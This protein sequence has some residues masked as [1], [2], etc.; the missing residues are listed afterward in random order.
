[1]AGQ[2][3]PTK[4][5]KNTDTRAERPVRGFHFICPIKEEKGVIPNRDG[6]FWTG[7]WAVAEAHAQLGKKID[8]YV[9]LHNAKSELSYRQ[10]V[11]KDYRVEERTGKGIQ[12]GIVFLV[13][14]TDTPLPW[15]GGGTGE[16]GYL[17]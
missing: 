11:I 17:R 15:R 6:T 8:A 12:S 14:P 3:P 2:K 1:M 13:E 7:I 9:A 5:P 4:A 10:G 16:K